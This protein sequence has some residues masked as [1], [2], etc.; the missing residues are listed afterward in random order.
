MG[1]AT[2]CQTALCLDVG[3]FHP[4]EVISDKISAAMLYVPTCFCT[5][6]A[7]Y[8]ET[9]TTWCCWTMKPRRL[10]VRSSFINLFDRVH[11]GLDFFDIINRIAAWV[12]DTC[13]MKK[14][15]LRT[16]LEPTEQLSQLE[17]RVTTPRVWYC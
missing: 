4:T 2:S 3:H 1:Y 7:W 14:A 13:N 5:L 12:I 6:A 16:L 8:V 11:I 15:L 9:A 17:A 10:P